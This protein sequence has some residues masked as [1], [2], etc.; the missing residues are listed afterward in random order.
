MYKV[1][2]RKR[3]KARFESHYL[4]NCVVDEERIEG[5]SLSELISHRDRSGVVTGR[6][7]N[8]PSTSHVE[9]PRCGFM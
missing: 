3:G 9:H 8:P 1:S 5:N 4:V 2:A 6:V 7:T